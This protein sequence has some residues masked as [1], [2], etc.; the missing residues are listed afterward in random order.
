MRHICLGTEGNERKLLFLWSPKYV[1][2]IFDI[3]SV[4]KN[5]GNLDYQTGIFLQFWSQFLHFYFMILDSTESV[6]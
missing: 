5:S 3:F 2:G 6:I 4:Q 1:W